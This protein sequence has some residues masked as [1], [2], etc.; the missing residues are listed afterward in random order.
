[1]TEAIIKVTP[2][3]WDAQYRD[4]AWDYLKNVTAHYAVIGSLVR[5][6]GCEYLLDVGC[7]TGGL[8]PFIQVEDYFGFDC[9]DVALDNFTNDNFDISLRDASVWQPSQEF[10]CAVFCESLY[11]MPDPLEVLTRYFEFCKTIFISMTST[12]ATNQLAKEIRERFTVVEKWELFNAD[13]YFI[14]MVVKP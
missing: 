8:V 9:S 5:K 4:G 13:H 3:E 6:H 11:Y 1:M 10:D 2:E 12:P 7:G 14:I